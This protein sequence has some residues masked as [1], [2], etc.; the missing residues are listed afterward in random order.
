MRLLLPAVFLS[1]MIPFSL[2]AGSAE[3]AHRRVRTNHAGAHCRGLSGNTHIEQVVVVGLDD[4][5]GLTFAR[6][7]IYV[8]DHGSLLGNIR[9]GLEWQEQHGEGMCW[10]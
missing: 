8:P 3:G 1:R 7:V 6:P 4:D 10:R 9:A 5:Q 2:Y